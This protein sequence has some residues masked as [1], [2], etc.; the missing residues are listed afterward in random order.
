MHEV[1][2]E[3]VELDIQRNRKH[4]LSLPKNQ[5]AWLRRIRSGEFWVVIVTPPCSTFSRAQWANDQGPAPVRSA[6]YPRGFPWNAAG[7]Q[8]KATLGNTLG[9]FSFE[10][11]RRQ[12]RHP[13]RVAMMEQ[14]EDLGTTKN[15]KIPGDKPASMWQSPQFLSALEE[16]LRTAVFSQLDLGRNQLNRSGCY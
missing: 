6:A 13:G 16:G 10:A 11:V 9:D 3:V 2:L 12:A 1:S 14:P 8:E 15:P 4:D 7:R 5:E